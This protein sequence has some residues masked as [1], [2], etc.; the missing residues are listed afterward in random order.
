MDVKLQCLI[1][2][3]DIDILGMGSDWDHDPLTC[4][5]CAYIIQQYNKEKQCPTCKKSFNSVK[6]VDVQTYLSKG[7]LKGI[8]FV[9]HSQNQLKALGGDMS[10]KEEIKALYENDQVREYIYHCT[11]PYCYDC[12]IEF[13]LY[14]EYKKHIE[15][16]HR[17]Y[18]CEL[19]L[20][21]RHCVLS[22]LQIFD[23]RADLLAHLNGKSGDSATSHQKC[24]F[25][26][27]YHDDRAALKKH[28]MD[29]HRVWE[30]CKKKAK[31]DSDYVFR[32]Y[33]AFMI[34][35]KENHL[36]CE[37]NDCD[38][39]FDNIT[40][41]DVH[42]AEFHGKTQLR[43]RTKENHE[44]EKEEV[45]KPEVTQE[46]FQ[47]MNKKKKE[48]FP[49]L[50]G[51]NN[52]QY[53]YNNGGDYEEGKGRGNKKNRK[54]NQHND[55]PFGGGGNRQALH[56]E[57]NF[58]TLDGRPMTASV[59]QDNYYEAPA[60]GGYAEYKQS[61]RKKAKKVVVDTGKPP[62]EEETP[63]DAKKRRKEERRMR[64]LMKE[65]VKETLE[66]EKQRIAPPAVDENPTYNTSSL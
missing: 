48:H 10:K 7:D 38:C 39:V 30:F 56:E 58:P 18:I 12:D 46:Q 22:D 49:T 62:E 52:N 6:Y 17:Q 51:N 34:H 13:K 24:Q 31:R 26:G 44:K 63:E 53:N 59:P 54:G 15:V 57:D 11:A 50:S 29:E 41:L 4:W 36:V 37:A 35:A 21:H 66:D 65:S 25:C 64:K 20:K 16:K 61:T 55:H 42:Q 60:T 45:K 27:T 33:K 32:D 40:S 1:C 43:I 14:I 23:T 2:C 28:Y 8:R 5:K 3:N 9:E 19:C 47:R